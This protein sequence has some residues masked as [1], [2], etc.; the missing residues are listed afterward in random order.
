MHN[1]KFLFFS[2]YRIFILLLLSFSQIGYADELEDNLIGKEK[3][4]DLEHNRTYQLAACLFFQNEAPYLKEWIEYHRLIGFEYFYLYNNESTDNYAEVLSPYIQEGIVELENVPGISNSQP[5][6]ADKQYAAYREAIAKAVGKVK[7]LALIDADEFIVPLQ[8]S[9]LMDVLDDYEDY[10]GVY[11]NWQLF[12]TSGYKTIPQGVLMIEALTFGLPQ[13][14]PLGKSI[15]RPERVSWCCN[16]HVHLYH[17]P[18]FHVNTNFEDFDCST[19]PIASDKLIINHYYTRDQD[20]LINV[21]YPR[22]RKWIEIEL[23]TYIQMLES[24]NVVQHLS[25]QKFVFKLRKRMNLR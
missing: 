10:G 20:H 25:I 13:P 16:A 15:V 14:Q 2:L 4:D 18:Y 24:I 3:V 23:N 9:Y 17:P 21:K 11:I 8:T 5:E 12:G 22:R 7:W 6:H 1:F 19:G